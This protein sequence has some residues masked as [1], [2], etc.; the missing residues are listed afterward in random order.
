MQFN[1]LKL[2]YVST[3]FYCCIIAIFKIILNRIYAKLFKPIHKVILEL[4]ELELMIF[5]LS[6]S[7]T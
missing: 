2:S 7:Y 1:P 6:L 3:T 5:C 4:R